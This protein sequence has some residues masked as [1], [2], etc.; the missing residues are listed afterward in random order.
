[1]LPAPPAR[2][3]GPPRVSFF[4]DRVDVHLCDSKGG[5]YIQGYHSVYLEIPQGAIPDG[6]PPVA[7]EMGIVREGPFEFPPNVK[8][9]SPVIWFCTKEFEFTRQLKITLPHFIGSKEENRHLAFFKASHIPETSGGTFSFKAIP[10]SD[11]VVFGSCQGT[12]C[13]THSCFLCICHNKSERVLANANYCLFSAIPKHSHI[14]SNDFDMHFCVSYFLPTC[15]EVILDVLLLQGD[16][17]VLSTTIKCILLVHGLC[18]GDFPLQTLHEQYKGYKKLARQLQ[19]NTEKGSKEAAIRI[20]FE[21][22]QPQGW[23]AAL[24]SGKWQVSC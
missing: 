19:L 10:D 15:V 20:A 11:S 7:I 16:L 14:E 6:Q 5:V 13:T 2:L 8:P 1:M 17:H 21:Q 3:R 24:V 4:N 12:L 22:E 18:L 9:V 23:V